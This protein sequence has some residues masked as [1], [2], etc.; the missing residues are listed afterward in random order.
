MTTA[1]ICCRP[2]SLCGV[3]TY[4]QRD[5]DHR[6]QISFDNALKVPLGHLEEREDGF[7][8]KAFETTEHRN[9]SLL[10]I[11]LDGMGQAALNRGLKRCGIHFSMATLNSLI[12]LSLVA[13][14]MAA[15]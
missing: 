14:E 6:G 7:N 13:P 5:Y 2:F 8:H 3:A 1:S 15:A 4:A 9:S 11:P 10:G 12:A